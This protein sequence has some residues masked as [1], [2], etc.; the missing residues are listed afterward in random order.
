MITS[1]AGLRRAWRVLTQR[2]LTSQRPTRESVARL[3]SP[4]IFALSAFG[5]QDCFVSFVS[6]V[7]QLKDF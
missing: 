5:D 7:V 6:F 3:P 1:A 2:S 4:A